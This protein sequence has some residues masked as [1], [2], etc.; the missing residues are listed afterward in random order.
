M[1]PS[2]LLKQNVDRSY[3]TVTHG[4]GVF[5]YDTEGRQY[6]DG[7]GGPMTA[8]IGHGV[9]E[10]ADAISAQLAQV[11]FSY[12]TQFTN[13]PAEDLARRLIDLAPGDLTAAFF[14]S[15]GSEATEYAMRA[16]VGYWQGRQQPDKVKILGRRI[17]YH[18]MTLG[19]LSMSGHAARRP[20]YGTLLHPFPVAPPAYA[21]RFA[22]P[23]ESEDQ[24]AERAAA[25]LE[26]SILGEDPA[27]VAAIIL[28]P[29]VGAAGGVL[30]PPA[31]YLARVR[32]ACDRL[33]VLLILDEVITGMGRTGEWFACT[34]EGVVPDLLVLG[35]GLS[36]GYAPMAGVLLREHLVDTM[37]RGSGIAPFGHTF[38]GNPLG[39][40]TCLAVIDHIEDNDLLVNTRERGHQLEAGL[41][42]LA[43]RFPQIADVRGRGL[44]WGFELVV[45]RHTR[46][47]P[48]PEHNA[49]SVLVE[50]CFGRGLV[51]YPAGVAPLNNAAII[52]PPLS[53][54]ADEVELLLA[55]LGDALEAVCSR[56]FLRASPGGASDPG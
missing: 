30:V 46:E 18:G 3:P 27:T 19:A 49:S 56:D 7:S 11:A 36:G 39:A 22:R 31:G 4:R 43:E 20:D 51:V 50:E 52:S 47:A 38:S 48:T 10:L 55:I 32:E 23:D 42:R 25:E 16:A 41:R 24:Y 40:A 45:D 21:Y 33:G 34:G 29:I 44:L 2:A 8:S 26:A 37:R 6:L 12:R 5:L 14:V 54:S 28:E 53:I 13:Q 35:K 1:T 17:S 15:S 9:P